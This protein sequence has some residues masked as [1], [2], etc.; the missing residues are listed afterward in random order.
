MTY[1]IG[2]I[3]ISV[4]LHGSKEVLAA[5]KNHGC[6]LM[7]QDVFGFV[8]E[9]LIIHLPRNDTLS[10]QIVLISFSDTVV[11]TLL[12]IGSFVI[13]VDQKKTTNMVIPQKKQRLMV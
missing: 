11:R 7:P 4:N 12:L 6:G 3:I 13:G 10:L 2:M 5:E 8:Q 1:F 9:G